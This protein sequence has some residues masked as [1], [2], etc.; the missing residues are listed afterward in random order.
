MRQAQ[1]VGDS[2]FGLACDVASRL[3]AHI[4]N[5]RENQLRMQMPTRQNQ[6][7]RRPQRAVRR[8]RCIQIEITA[9][10]DITQSRYHHPGAGSQCGLE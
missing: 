7:Y 4:D 9:A 3:A 8:V 5:R 6:A 1:C 2:A 10:L